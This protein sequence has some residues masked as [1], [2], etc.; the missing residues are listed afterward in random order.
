MG[1]FS[2]YCR[3]H[4]YFLNKHKLTR[5][6][7]IIDVRFCRTEQRALLLSHGTVDY[8]SFPLV[9]SR[10]F[11]AQK[12]IK[13]LPQRA[14]VILMLFDVRSLD[15]E[16]S[17]YRMNNECWK[18][19]ITSQWLHFTAHTLYHNTEHWMNL[20]INWESQIVRLSESKTYD[21]LLFFVTV[22]RTC[23][24]RHIRS[25]S[26]TSSRLFKL[27]QIQYNHAYDFH[28]IHLFLILFPPAIFCH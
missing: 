27:H 11:A 5:P 22:V 26:C 25:Y 16:T 14:N 19:H 10:L 3:G 12:V 18:A 15:F 13:N 17:V 20:Q 9:S 8:F 28:S 4:R 7:K 2:M 24:Y 21:T 23:S 1:R 6:R